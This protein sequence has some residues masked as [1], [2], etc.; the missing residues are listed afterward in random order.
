MAFKGKINIV[1]IV[2]WGL[3]AVLAIAA[4]AL[5]FLGRKQAGQAAGLRD[6]LSQVATTAGV[7]DLTPD[8]LMASA[9]L[10]DVLQ[11]TQT[12]IQSVQQE[13]ATTKE[14]LSL[15]RDEA[16]SAKTESGNLSQQ[17][18]EQTT[19]AEGLAKNLTVQEEAA[20]AA[21]AEAEKAVQEAKALQEA[22]DRQKAELEGNLASLK[23][24]MEEE[25]ARLQKEL[26]DLRS[27]A[28]AG[29]AAPVEG[30]VL[31][32]ALAEVSL[33]EPVVE[34][35]PGRVIGQSDMISLIRYDEVEQ[36]LF[37][38]LLDGQELTYRE[39]PPSAFGQLVADGARVD[40]IYKFKIQGAFKSLP[41][42][43]TVVRKFWKWKRR[44]KTKGEVRVIEV[45]APPAVV[46]PEVSPVAT[47]PVASAEEVVS[48][49][50]AV[51]MESE[52]TA[53]VI[54]SAAPAEPAALQ[55]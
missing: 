31:T 13:L 39:V 34:E 1:G 35:E 28:S 52:T 9:A 6:A 29:P 53:T 20:T 3:V 32:D 44:N 22:A 45:L 14:S 42:D 7:P 48:E 33:E 46:E 19:R 25:T 24:R 11:K 47:E 54:K 36:S 10:P 18:Q 41:P 2:A 23:A 17:V 21:K 12:A 51:M 30:D 15:A 26:D 38:R 55:E 27:Q 40:V 4:G 5:G 49:A 43:S 8:A 50:L 16:S 37:L